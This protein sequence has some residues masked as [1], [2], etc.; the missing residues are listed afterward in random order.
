MAATCNFT[1]RQLQ[2]RHFPVK[3][4][5]AFQ[6]LQNTCEQLFSF[7]LYLLLTLSSMFQIQKKRIQDPVKH[8][9]WNFLRKQLISKSYQLFSKKIFLNMSRRRISV[10]SFLFDLVLILSNISQLFF[11]EKPQ[12][13]TCVFNFSPCLD[14][15][16][17]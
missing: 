9:R 11:R 5:K 8:L 10:H 3:F 4:A 17:A 12:A 15:I 13:T 7:T 14:I 16:K 6:I 2:C 1:K